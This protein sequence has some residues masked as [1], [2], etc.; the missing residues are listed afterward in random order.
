MRNF[1]DEN[2]MT[3]HEFAV[4]TG[5]STSTVNRAISNKTVTQKNA[6][7]IFSAT[8]GKVR[9]RIM[10]AG[11]KK[12]FK[13]KNVTRKVKHDMSSTK[14]F[15]IWSRMNRACYQQDFFQFKSYGKLGVRVCSS[16]R[17]S[18][19][20]FYKDMGPIPEGYKSMILDIKSS[21]YQKSSCK[22]IRDARG[23]R[24]TSIKDPIAP[25]PMQSPSEVVSPRKNG[26]TARQMEFDENMN[27]TCVKDGT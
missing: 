19:S 10:N 12:G 17:K 8:K 20:N 13:V 7:I 16:W 25:K 18:F 21:V 3:I 27:V 11:R 6:A 5:L 9:L 22:W 4:F 24:R 14:E 26:S 1:L 15:R 2:K 23:K